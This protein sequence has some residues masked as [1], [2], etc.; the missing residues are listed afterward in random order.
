MNENVPSPLP[1]VTQ[2]VN[3]DAICSRDPSPRSFDACVLESDEIL[4]AVAYRR[5]RWYASCFLH[6]EHEYQKLK[7]YSFSLEGSF[8]VLIEEDER[9]VGRCW[10][11]RQTPAGR[12]VSAW[13]AAKV[14]REGC[15]SLAGFRGVLKGFYL[16]LNKGWGIRGVGKVVVF[17]RMLLC[18]GNAVFIVERLCFEFKRWLHVSFRVMI[19]TR[20]RGSGAPLRIS[21]CRR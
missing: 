13:N 1:F 6:V 2:P 9:A 21:F 14:F 4:F 3:T 12:S 11:R 17:A 15:S 16:C 20:Y 5:V 8:A 7:G 19:V 10:G 18:G